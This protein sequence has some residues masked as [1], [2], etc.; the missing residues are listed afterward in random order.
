MDFITLH[1]LSRELNIPAR[2]VRYRFHQ[3]RESGKLIEH[4]DFR[5]D[6]YVDE[7][8]FTWKINPLSYMR[9]T[10]KNV[11]PP[12]AGLDFPDTPSQPLGSQVVNKHETS[13][14]NIDTNITKPIN[15][16]NAGGNE[17]G[18]HV[19]TKP[20]A[21][22]LEREMIEFMKDQIHEKDQQLKTKDEQI[23]V[24]SE[25]LKGTTELNIK[26]V[27]QNVHQG[28]RIQELLQLASA[29]RH[30]HAFVTKDGAPKGT[31]GNHVVNQ[32]GN[33]DNNLD[34]NGSSSGYHQPNPQPEEES[35]N[36]F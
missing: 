26:L 28:E 19:E 8:H 35:G 29:P 3:L 2:V 18:S 34:T 36:A 16:V 1:D 12:P 15:K 23:K 33:V 4:E 20:E 5:R 21:P 6:D 24:I 14:N 11:A 31:A 27:G 25:Q 22:P 7:Q 17:R 10:G 30:E 32:D 13:V 9:E